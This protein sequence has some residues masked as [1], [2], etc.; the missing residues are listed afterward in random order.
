MLYTSNVVH[1]LRAQYLYAPANPEPILNFD[2]KCDIP[3]SDR[4]VD[5]ERAF[6][7]STD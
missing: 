4:S 5:F 2:W 7:M 3:R 1:H 6:A